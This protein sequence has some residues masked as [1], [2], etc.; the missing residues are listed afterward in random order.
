MSDSLQPYGLQPTRL[1]CPWDSPGKNSGVGYH[2]LGDL[3]NPGI[4][5]TSVLSPAL[6]GRFLTTST[7][8]DPLICRLFSNKYVIT[9]LH[10][11]G[12]VESADILDTEA[13][14]TSEFG[15]YG[16]FAPLTPCSWVNCI[17]QWSACS[18][19][20]N[21]SGRCLFHLLNDDRMCIS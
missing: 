17:F 2:V 10:D 12:L 5:P 4:E 8:W 3:P 1:L 15:L 14:V 16:G 9:G 18:K 6:T 21:V 7:T 19:L 11:P 13:Q 20:K